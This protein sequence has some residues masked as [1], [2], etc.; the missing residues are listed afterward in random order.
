MSIEGIDENGVIHFTPDR[1]IQEPVVFIGLTDSEVV[2]I[3]VVS[4]LVGVP[5][6]VLL[7]LP[8]GKG[9]LGVALGFAIAVLSIYLI[10]RKLRV[11]KRQYPDG[12]HTVYL[13]QVLQKKTPLNYGYV[14]FQGQ[15][16]IRRSQVVTRPQRSN[17][18]VSMKDVI[19]ECDDLSSFQPQENKREAS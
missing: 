15:W 16:S 11:L 17:E 7:L 14:D 6:G 1:L 2:Q 9:F 12:L 3:S 4:V 13:Q 10:G 8:F 19:G 5:F 18:T